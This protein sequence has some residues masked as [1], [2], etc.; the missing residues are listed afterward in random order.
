LHRLTP[1]LAKAKS[2]IGN[3][4]SKMESGL[5]SRSS[6]RDCGKVKR[7]RL[8]QGYGGSAKIDLRKSVNGLRTFGELA[9]IL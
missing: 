3:L 6:L 4:K 2:K 8:R 9:A 1:D 7:V 5:P